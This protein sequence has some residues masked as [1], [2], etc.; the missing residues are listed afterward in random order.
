LTVTD[1]DGATATVTHSVTVSQQ[2]ASTST[3]F[4]VDSPDPT[5]PGQPF[6]VTLSVRSDEGTPQG[7]ATVSDGVN[8]CVVQIVGG[9][10]SCS[11]ALFTLGARTLTATFQGN[12]SFAS[13]SANETHTVNPPAVQ[14]LS[15]REQPS[16]SVTIGDEF[17]RQPEIELRLGDD[18]LEQSGVT[19]TAT[20][21]SGSGTLGGTV[22]ALTD[23][24]GRAR[25]D[26]LSISGAT[27]T[28]T[29]RFTADGFG[30]VISNPIEVEQES[31][32][33]Q[34]TSF[35]PDD[36]IVGQTVRVSFSVTGD[37]GTPTGN[38]TVTADG[39]GETCTGAV[40]QGFCDLVFTA[41]GDN[42]DVTATY[43]GDGRFEGDTDTAEI[44]VGP[45]PPVNQAPT[46]NDD[47]AT[48]D[49]GV[50]V[51]IPVRANDT[52]PEGTELTIGDVSS[53]ANGGI[54][55]NNGD[56]TITYTPAGGF[57]GSDSFTYTA[58]DGSLSD[59]ATVTVT[60]NAPPAPGVLGLRTEPPTAIPSGQVLQPEP[61]VELLGASGD[62]LQVA[63]VTV[64]AAPVPA[65]AATLDGTT[66]LPTDG[67]GRVRFEDLSI[68]GAP[69]STVVLAFTAEGF[70]EVDSQAILIQSN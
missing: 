51:T 3:R 16:S 66:S 60:V 39:P 47:V 59:A 50:A 34:I 20:I 33:I 64:G 36:P 12:A 7:T 46:A 27:G 40:S 56:G 68:E 30:E 69:G 67:N 62:P 13:S 38:V 61:E 32:Q 17:S 2:A 37:G 55:V 45:A 14:S 65:D 31:S 19:V 25:F 15:I 52:D 70:A 21:A 6:T 24:D 42:R 1:D 54:A 53:P 11:L 10:G 22:T 9:S 41:P 63:G 28:H 43:G 48:T 26:D 23:G 5:T 44:D 8:D 4:E 18:R 57:S 35:D 58:S 49:A 29:L